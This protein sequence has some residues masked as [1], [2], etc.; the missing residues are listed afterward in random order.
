L[1]Q[2]AR[3]NEAREAYRTA[4]A[5]A[6]LEPERRLLMARIASIDGTPFGE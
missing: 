3:P 1:Q 6:T 5:F 2:L 4:L